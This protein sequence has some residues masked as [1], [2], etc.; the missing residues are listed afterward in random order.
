MLNSNISTVG[1]G[2]VF[3]GKSSQAP[4]L[5]VKE[6]LGVKTKHLDT[7]SN[8]NN[9]NGLGSCGTPCKNKENKSPAKSPIGNGIIIKP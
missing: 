4:R 5:H 2:S 6:R 3:P 7:S 1:D 8:N 9:N